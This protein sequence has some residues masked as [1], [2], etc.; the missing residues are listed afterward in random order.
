MAYSIQSGWAFSTTVKVQFLAG[1][2]AA[3]QS[4]IQRRVEVRT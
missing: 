1:S 3:R 2:S 4:S